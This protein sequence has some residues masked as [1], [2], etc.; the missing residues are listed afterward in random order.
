M[1]LK[2]NERTGVW[3]IGALG[4]VSTCTVLGASA[5]RRGAPSTGLVSALPEFSR[6]NLTPVGELV[7]GGH[8]V[9]AGSPLEEACQYM[10]RN[11]VPSSE[12]IDAARDDLAAFEEEIRPGILLNCGRAVEAL[13]NGRA[14]SYRTSRT[15]LH[16]VERIIE[17]LRGFQARHSLRDVVVVNLASS[18]PPSPL[19]P[20]K[21]LRSMRRSLR[22][23]RKAE[24]TSSLLYAWAAI[25]AGF[26]YINFTASCG[27]SL[28]AMDELARDRKVPHM[29][30]D[31]KTGETLVKTAL[32]PMLLARNFRLLA[33]EGYNLLGNRDGLVLNDPNHAR[34]KISDKASVL[35]AIFPDQ[36]FH[37]QVRI[38]Y[39]P[40]LEDWKTAWD[41]I[42][43]EGFLGTRMTMQFTWQG[44]DSMLAAPLVLDLAR[45]A[46]DAHR[47][48]MSGHMP[49]LS[50]FFKAPFQVREQDFFAQFR[51]LREYA[52]S[53]AERPRD[54]IP[55]DYASKSD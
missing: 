21:D 35:T 7:F 1:P 15:L 24:W 34:A 30:K 3:L 10:R 37:S 54:A 19:P 12:A 51:M 8:E 18:E 48:G 4:S 29:G 9:R 25:D 39:V 5:L 26:P 33:W 46:E 55:T 20:A 49:H 27:S 2:H 41:L 45:F 38:D 17:H 36:N 44:C 11:G 42:Q 43:F 31:G 16:L 22:R 40:T 14:E 13:L 50:C 52:A 28:P 32:A 23:N 6:L 47:R 53:R